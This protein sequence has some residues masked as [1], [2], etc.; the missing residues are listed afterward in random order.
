MN[1]T[2]LFFVLVVLALGMCFA[3]TPSLSSTHRRIPNLKI[4]RTMPAGAVETDFHKLPA[5]GYNPGYYCPMCVNFMINAINE[6]LNIIAN[7]GIIGGCSAL[8]SL[9]PNSIEAE[10]CDILCTIVGIEGFIDLIN[11]T[12]P[13]PLWICMELDQTCPINDDAKANITELIV[14][15]ASGP[16]GTT[17]NIQMLYRVNNTIGTGEVEFIVIPPDAMPF[18]EGALIVWQPPGPYGAS[19]SFDA[20]P[21][22]NEPFNPGTYYVQGALCEGS[23]GSIHSHSFTLDVKQTKFM[24]TNS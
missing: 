11:D 13:D 19:L 8:C 7:G 9:L 22:E 5:E 18:G 21:G 23:C 6:L 2:V 20:S 10:I 3:A 14:K 15:P 1:N 16:Q 4:T 24:I 12:D 17:F